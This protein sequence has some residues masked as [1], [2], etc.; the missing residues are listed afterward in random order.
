MQSGL[1]RGMFGKEKGLL[2]CCVA[3]VVH[4]TKQHAH[5]IIQKKYNQ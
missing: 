2:K 5:F 4:L 3:N 1:H